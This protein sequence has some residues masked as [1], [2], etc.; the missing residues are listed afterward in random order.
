MQEFADRAALLGL[1][2]RRFGSFTLPVSG[3]KVRFR[4]LTE[5]ELSRFE[6]ALFVED[7]TAD[8]GYRM[9]PGR[10]DDIRARLIVI[11]VCD[12]EG[13]LLFSEADVPA[14]S[15]F[16]PADLVPLYE[17]IQKHC[18]IADAA[19]RRKRRAALKKTSNGT[20]DG[21]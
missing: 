11:T 4:S 18:G 15:T 10:L 21:D 17:Q 8:S 2:E 6:R 20:G 3:K 14:V 5:L 1:A 16:D 19:E 9:E 7:E 12:G 13:E